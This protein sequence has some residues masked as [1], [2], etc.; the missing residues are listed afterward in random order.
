VEFVELGLP[1]GPRLILGQPR[2]GDDGELWW[3]TAT[4]E[5]DGLKAE[6]T[7]SAHYATCMDEL[8]TYFDDLATNWSGWEGIKRYESVEHDLVLQSRHDGYG[9]VTI[10]IMLSKMD[11]SPGEWECTGRIMTDPGAQMEEA[12]AAARQLLTRFP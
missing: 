5:L 7:V 4:L 12:A 9:H 6:K 1:G 8:I 3:V 11:G 2:R 10:E